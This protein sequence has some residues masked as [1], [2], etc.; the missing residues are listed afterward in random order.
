ME[1]TYSARDGRY[2][3]IEVRR[4]KGDIKFVGDRSG[5]DCYHT[6]KA[7]NFAAFIVSINQ[8]AGT[9]IMTAIETVLESDPA[10]LWGAIHSD[11]TQT[12]FSW[13]SMSEIEDMM[14]F[15]DS[16]RGE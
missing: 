15:F 4:E 6:L 10:K 14:D 13:Q 16:V 3:H 9:E 2:Q 7:E 8:P 5:S 12:D 1:K 11:V